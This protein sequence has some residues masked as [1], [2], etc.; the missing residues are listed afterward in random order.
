MTVLTASYAE[1][2]HFAYLKRLPITSPG[3]KKLFIQDQ[4][5]LWFVFCNYGEPYRSSHTRMGTLLKRGK[6]VGRAVVS[7][8]YKTLHWLS[9]DSL[10]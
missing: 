1:S 2:L 4:K 10:S 6:E 8:E 9:C 3:K 7:K 5:E